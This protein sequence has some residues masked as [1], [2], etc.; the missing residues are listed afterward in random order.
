M[1]SMTLFAVILTVGLSLIFIWVCRGDKRYG[2]SPRPNSPQTNQSNHTEIPMSDYE[3]FKLTSCDPPPYETPDLTLVSPDNGDS[4]APLPMS[5][6]DDYTYITAVPT[7][8][9]EEPIYTSADPPPSP[10]HDSVCDADAVYS[11]ADKP[12]DSVSTS[13]S[14]HPLNPLG[15]PE[16]CVYSTAELPTILSGDENGCSVTAVP[17]DLQDDTYHLADIPKSPSGETA[18]HQPQTGVPNLVSGD[19]AYSLAELPRDLCDDSTYSLA[20]LPRSSSAEIIHSNS[21]DEP[22]YSNSDDSATDPQDD[23]TY[24]TT[25]SPIISHSPIYSVLE[26]PTIPLSDPPSSN[27]D[28][29]LNSQDLPYPAAELPTNPSDDPVYAETSDTALDPN[30]RAEHLP[31]NPL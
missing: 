15:S 27:P 14:L 26:S 9:E 30:C 11:K 10:G 1:T 5:L 21:T 29:S 6:S 24:S 13:S 12:S 3:E 8:S 19:N 22:V 4:I 25:E 7:S 17:H 20:H 18:Q 23:S 2:P 28:A 31:I 16:D